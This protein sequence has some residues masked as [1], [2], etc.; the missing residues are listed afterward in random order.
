MITSSLGLCGAWL[1]EGFPPLH[2]AMV[3]GRLA[4]VFPRNE[5]LRSAT[6]SCRAG[7]CV[8]WEPPGGSGALQQ[9]L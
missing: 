7:G 3:A 6:Q 5:I 2:N 4:P 8:S 9:H 1:Q